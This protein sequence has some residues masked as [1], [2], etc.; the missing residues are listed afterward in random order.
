MVFPRE[1]PY[2]AF[3]ALPRRSYNGLSLSLC[4]FT[5]LFADVDTEQLNTQIHSDTDSVFFACDNSTTGHICNDIQ[6]FVPESLYQTNKSPTTTNGTGLC[7]QE[8][9]VNISLIDD[10]GT[11]H[12]FILD[13]CLYHPDSPFNLLS[14]R[15]LAKKFIGANGNPD[16]ET[17]IES[18]YSTHVLTWSFGQYRKMFPHQFLA[19]LNFYSTRG[20]KNINHFAQRFHLL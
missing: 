8:G 12:A 17:R 13:S 15:H 4:R 7:L 2:F 9:T 19:F 3:H 20:F 5:T 16:K 11:R 10:N 14:M 18:H 6:R 1:I